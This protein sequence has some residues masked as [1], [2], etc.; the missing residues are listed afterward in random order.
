MSNIGVVRRSS[1]L[2]RTN[3]RLPPRSLHALILNILRRLPEGDFFD[4]SM[5]CIVQFKKR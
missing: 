1:S 3:V 5:E 4:P 2:R